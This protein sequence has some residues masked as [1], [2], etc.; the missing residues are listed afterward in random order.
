MMSRD[1]RSI[2]QVL[3]LETLRI[4]GRD[5]Q[6]PP[7]YLEQINDILT[8]VASNLD[9]GKN[10]AHAILYECVK[11]IFAIQS[12]QSLKILGLIF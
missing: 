7:Q 9:S 6:C 5:E 1:Y 10:A 3:L 8:Q 11:T 12:D 4:L 2:L